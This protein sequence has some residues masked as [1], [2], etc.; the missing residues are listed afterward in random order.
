MLCQ[1]CHTN[2]ST[3]RY[4]E[5]V[6]GKVTDLRL[7]AD[8][9]ARHQQNESVG[10]GLTSEP[11]PA[12]RAAASRVPEA[13]IA[14]QRSCPTCG[15]ELSEVVSKGRVGCGDCYDTFLEQL[16]PV[17]RGINVGLLHR[18]KIPRQTDLRERT[19]ADLQ[20]KRALLRSS[21]RL[22]NYEEAAALRDQ[23]RSLE[24]TLGVAGNAQN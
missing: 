24:D 23:I 3:V 4:A 8:C 1:M 7:C 10:F 15:T 22:E 9:L 6:N 2:L 20:R 19:R 14:P 13:P 16:E 11:A 17:L 21:L 18:G 12:S 5:V